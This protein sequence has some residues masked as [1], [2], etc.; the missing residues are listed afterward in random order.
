MEG[1]SEIKQDSVQVVWSSLLVQGLGAGFAFLFRPGRVTGAKKFTQDTWVANVTADL[2]PKER[3]KAMKTVESLEKGKKFEFTSEQ[4]QAIE[5]TEP[6]RFGAGKIVF[7]TAQGEE[8]VK[9]AG[10]FGT[11]TGSLFT[12]L[13]ERFNAFAPGKV[14]KV[15]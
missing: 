15:G 6:G 5:F 14:R 3:T 10:S 2:D 9:I 13:L 8:V 7:R 11:G 1:P 4:V 12:A